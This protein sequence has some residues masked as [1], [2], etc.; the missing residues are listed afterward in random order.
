MHVLEEANKQ[1]PEGEGQAEACEKGRK[2]SWS[3]GLMADQSPKIG[4]TP[5]G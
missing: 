1:A 4:M 3:E 5:P 2:D